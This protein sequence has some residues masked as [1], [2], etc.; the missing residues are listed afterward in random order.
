MEEECSLL[1][2]YYSDAPEHRN[3]QEYL[4]DR[5]NFPRKNLKTM[6]QNKLSKFV[7]S[8]DRKTLI[9]IFLKLQYNV[10]CSSAFALRQFRDK[11]PQID[12]RI[13]MLH[14]IHKIASICSEKPRKSLK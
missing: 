14:Y 1:Q 6:L 8:R 7:G 10:S 2:K 11:S 5:A 4:P 13:P 12:L 3:F 9:F